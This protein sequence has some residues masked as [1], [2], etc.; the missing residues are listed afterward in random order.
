MDLKIKQ[1]DKNIALLL[2]TD[3]KKKLFRDFHSILNNFSGLS[4]TS[5]HQSA[6][7]NV[8]VFVR[9]LDKNDFYVTV[10]LL[11]ENSIIKYTIITTPRAETFI[12]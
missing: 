7:E 10:Q 4:P 11:C 3:K 5:L 1:E 12:R 6:E 8:T 9:K 2:P